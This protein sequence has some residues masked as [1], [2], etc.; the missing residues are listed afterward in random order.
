MPPPGATAMRV[1][2]REMRPRC[3]TSGSGVSSSQPPAATA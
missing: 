2:C 3:G 1:T